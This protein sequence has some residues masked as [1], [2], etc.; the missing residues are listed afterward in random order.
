[1]RILVTGGTVFVS[2][3]IAT[4]FRDRGN[5][6]YVLNRGTKKQIDRVTLISADRHSLADQLKNIHFDVVVDVTAYSSYDI[7]TLLN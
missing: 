1:M 5:E 3:N 4:Y 2:K 6:V 7:D